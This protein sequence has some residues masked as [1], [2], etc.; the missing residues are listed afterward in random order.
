MCMCCRVQDVR[1]SA[2]GGPITILDLCSGVGYLSL[3]LS[4]LLES[5]GPDVVARFVLVDEAWPRGD[6]T[7]PLRPGHINKDHLTLEG[8][9]SHEILC[10]KC[11][12]KSSYGHRELAKYVLARAPG[13][14]AVLGVHLCGLL[15]LKAVQFYN[16]HPRCSFFALKV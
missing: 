3:L 1:P 5:S 10:R 7:G 11:D 8:V 9:W 4:E 16:D 15:S 13:P 2:A 6:N 12:F 14:V